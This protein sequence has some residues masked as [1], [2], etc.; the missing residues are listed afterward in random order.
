MKDVLLNK[1]SPINGYEHIERVNAV[2]L[3]LEQSVQ[4]DSQ[5]VRI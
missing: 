3:G 1:V 5:K 2:L 4:N